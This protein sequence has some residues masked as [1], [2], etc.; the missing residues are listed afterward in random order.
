MRTRK[1][2]RTFMQLVPTVLL[3]AGSAWA[4]GFDPCPRSAL[5]DPGPTNGPYFATVTPNESFTSRRA[6]TFPFTCNVAELAG[7]RGRAP[8]SVRSGDEFRTIS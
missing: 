8:L 5:L 1:T 6:H 2:I 4:D 3:A 7:R